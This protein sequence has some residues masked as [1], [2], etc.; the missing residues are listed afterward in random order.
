LLIE[1]GAV[2]LKGQTGARIF[3]RSHAPVEITPGTE[4]SELIGA[5]DAI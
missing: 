2:T 4:I 3:R 5:P 1:N